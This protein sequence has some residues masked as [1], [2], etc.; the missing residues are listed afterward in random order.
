MNL[1]LSDYQ[2]RVLDIT[3][4]D[5]TRNLTD[6]IIKGHEDNEIIG[7]ATLA[8]RRQVLED[9]LADLRDPR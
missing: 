4:E 8:S 5:A 7:P 1:S 2:R 9:L 6:A 3:L